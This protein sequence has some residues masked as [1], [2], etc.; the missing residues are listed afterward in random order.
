MG[1]MVSRRLREMTDADIAKIAD[2][3]VQFDNGSLE[4]VKGFCAV[5]ETADIA[6]HDYILTPGRYVGLEEQED[7]GVPF[8]EKFAALKSTLE[9]QF[10]E[11]DKLTQTIREKLSI[12]DDV[13]AGKVKLSNGE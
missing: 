13:L 2:T 5:A 3:F 10:A 12:I 6:K 11:S 7:D 4:E 9:E 8:E 1:T